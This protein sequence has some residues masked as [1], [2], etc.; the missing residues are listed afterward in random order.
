M[1][2]LLCK[3]HNT[4]EVPVVTVRGVV[5]TAPAV[6]T[7]GVVKGVDVTV[8]SVV[9]AR[10]LAVVGD[11]VVNVVGVVVVSAQMQNN[12]QFQNNNTE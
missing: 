6:V 2:I 12:M 4:I 10:V 3:Y 9:D 1:S 7:V 5:V 11:A 8:V